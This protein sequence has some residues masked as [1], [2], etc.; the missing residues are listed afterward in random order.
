MNATLLKSLAALLPVS[1]V[2]SGSI[3]LFRKGKTVPALLQLIGTGCLLLVVLT[4]VSEALHLFPWM[5]WG[6]EGSAGHY[7]DLSSAVLGLTLFPIGYLLHAL[8]L[9][10]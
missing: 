10:E 5:G 4:H 7:I 1:L 2:F 9:W 8:N 3:L 6:M